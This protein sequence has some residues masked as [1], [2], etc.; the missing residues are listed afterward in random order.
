MQDTKMYS[1]IPIKATKELCTVVALLEKHL[2]YCR[3]DVSS[4]FSNSIIWLHFI[5]SKSILVSMA[6]LTGRAS[7]LLQ[8]CQQLP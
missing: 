6:D 1:Y 8:S 4:A 5:E 3:K 2:D 7:K